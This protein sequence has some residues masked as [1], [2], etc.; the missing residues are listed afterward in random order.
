MV[1]MI[2][3]PPITFLMYVLASFFLPMKPIVREKTGYYLRDSLVV[4]EKNLAGQSERVSQ[5]ESY[6]TSQDFDIKTKINL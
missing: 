5:L 4:L 6:I 3:L 2:I 1:G